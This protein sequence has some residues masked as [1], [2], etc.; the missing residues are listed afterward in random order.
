MKDEIFNVGLSSAN[1]SKK[2]LCD[3]IKKQVPDVAIIEANIRK[4][5]D[6]RNYIVS[7]EKLEQTGWKPQYSIDDGIRELIKGFSY[8][9]KVG[10]SNV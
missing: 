10:H 7:N 9:R 4:D 6:Q 5:I 2:E 1:L 8:L 3:K